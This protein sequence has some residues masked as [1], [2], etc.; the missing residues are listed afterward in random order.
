M[1]VDILPEHVGGDFEQTQ[2]TLIEHLFF[3]IIAAVLSPGAA[4]VATRSLIPTLWSQVSLQ[5]SRFV[6]ELFTRIANA[7][8]SIGIMAEIT[9]TSH[10]L[11]GGRASGPVNR[12]MG[13]KGNYSYSNPLFYF[14]LLEL[15]GALCRCG[16]RL[17]YMENQGKQKSKFKEKR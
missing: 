3:V 17:R 6:D 14:S 13:G 16:K 7:L 15:Q 11:A 10:T 1:I 12:L 9:M 8:L 2:K 4:H 5:R